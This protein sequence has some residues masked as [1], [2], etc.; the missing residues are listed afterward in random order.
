MSMGH[1]LP[2][3]GLWSTISLLHVSLG[4]LRVSQEHEIVC[5]SLVW[6]PQAVIQEC[7]SFN[8]SRV[9]PKADELDRDLALVKVAVLELR[10]ELVYRTLCAASAF[11]ICCGR[12]PDTTGQDIDAD[13]AGLVIL[14]PVPQP[15][16]LSRPRGQLADDF[17]SQCLQCS[18]N[19]AIGRGS[20]VEV[21][22]YKLKKFICCFAVLHILR[23]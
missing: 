18:F 15:F 1:T 21:A 4:F 11:S 22:L 10:D 13:R 5:H 12:V 16:L 8:P 2:L 14:N 17:T 20:L 6:L 19:E 9:V 23:I 3:L 7:Q